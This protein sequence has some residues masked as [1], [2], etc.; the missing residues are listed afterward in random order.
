MGMRENAIS[1][2]LMGNIAPK[3]FVCKHGHLVTHCGSAALMHKMKKLGKNG[4]TFPSICLR[5][6]GRDR[7]RSC[8]LSLDLSLELERYTMGHNSYFFKAKLEI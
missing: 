7:I 5:G 8:C 3:A 1:F 6:R 2:R 4:I